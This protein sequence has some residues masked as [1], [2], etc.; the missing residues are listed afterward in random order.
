[1]PAVIF[2]CFQI[3]SSLARF[4]QELFW[5]YLLRLSSYHKQIL[6]SGLNNFRFII[7][8]CAPWTYQLLGRM[9][10]PLHC[11]Y[12]FQ[13]PSGLQNWTRVRRPFEKRRPGSH[14]VVTI[15]KVGSNWVTENSMSGGGIQRV[16]A[17]HK[18][19]T[20]WPQK[21]PE[22]STNLFEVVVRLPGQL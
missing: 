20:Y 9:H 6:L 11:S 21:S 12:S 2:R 18:S 17:M 16:A 22:M 14:V 15:R 8:T 7:N 19:Q 3:T 4:V 13:L 1:M 10:S 5:D